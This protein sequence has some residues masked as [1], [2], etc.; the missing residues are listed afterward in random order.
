MDRVEVRRTISASAGRIWR[1]FTDLSTM[2]GFFFGADVRTDWQVGH[3]IT[4]SG[5]YQRKTYE[6]RGIV[7]SFEPERRLTFT[8]WS[9][10]SGKPDLPEHRHIVTLRL[11]PHGDSTEVS[12]VQENLAGASPE[13]L[14][15]NW[16]ALLE[17]LSRVVEAESYGSGPQPPAG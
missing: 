17:G 8:H 4:F 10:L 15:K 5:S 12:I 7:Q 2:K 16:S 1:A 13:H 3:P 14:R 6:D 9:P 11:E